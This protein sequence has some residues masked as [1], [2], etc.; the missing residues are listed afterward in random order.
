MPQKVVTRDELM[1]VIAQVMAL[2]NPGFDGD[3]DVVLSGDADFEL[4]DAIG[5][6]VER[7]R[8]WRGE[9]GFHEID[10]ESIWKLASDR[11][12]AA[13]QAEKDRLAA[14]KAERKAAAKAAEKAE[15]KR[16]RELEKLIRQQD[17]DL[18]KAERKA[19]AKAAAPPAMKSAGNATES[20]A[21]CAEKRRLENAAKFAEPDD[22]ADLSIPTFMRRTP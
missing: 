18:A 16:E 10:G 17:K 1:A 12:E 14:E 2:P 19:A 15:R 21:D 3:I 8:N 11:R 20:A 22:P 7:L 9:I 13:E 6:A 4:F 5:A